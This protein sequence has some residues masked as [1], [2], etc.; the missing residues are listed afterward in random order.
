MPWILFYHIV[1]KAIFDCYRSAAHFLKC[2][3]LHN[4]WK[5]LSGISHQ[6]VIQA[7][8]L[9]VYSQLSVSSN[10]AVVCSIN[11]SNT[12][13]Y[14]YILTSPLALSEISYII[15][16][17][18]DKKCNFYGGKSLQSL[19][20]QL[21]KCNLFGNGSLYHVYNP[22]YKWVSSQPIFHQTERLIFW[23]K[24]KRV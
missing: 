6:H 23:N 19:F 21:Q 2:L 4:S 8:A 5:R 18:Y 16:D 15:I 14:F 24:L 20:W 7:K 13:S 11:M 3:K 17:F 12:V 10:S 22:H 1:Q 9:G